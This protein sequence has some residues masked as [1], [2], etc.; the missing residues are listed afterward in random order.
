MHAESQVRVSS[1]VRPPLWTSYNEWPTVLNWPGMA[2]RL[3]RRN[4]KGQRRRQLPGELRTLLRMR[5]R[6]MAQRC[7][8][9]L[10]AV[11]CAHLACFFPSVG[12]PCSVL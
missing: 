5:K 11:D 10:P 2:A 3:R 7:A 9:R 12:K 6:T 8:H 1:A 4:R